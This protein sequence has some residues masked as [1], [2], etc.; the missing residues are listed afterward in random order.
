[1]TQR[2]VRSSGEFES[3]EAD[4]EARSRMQSETK[5]QACRRAA[6]RSELKNVSIFVSMES[7]LLFDRRDDGW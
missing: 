7:R 6:C 2:G 3:R 4:S 1:M 5:V